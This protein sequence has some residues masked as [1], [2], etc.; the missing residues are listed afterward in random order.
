[1]VLLT[2][3]VKNFCPLKSRG[4]R[5]SGTVIPE[6]PRKC[7]V[8]EILLPEKFFTGA[9]SLFSQC[10]GQCVCQDVSILLFISLFMGFFKYGVWKT[11][12]IG[13]PFRASKVNSLILSDPAEM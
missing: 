7:G 2:E 1:M 4:F 3:K 6:N 5:I 9:C 12:K 11:L 10:F 8:S 13:E